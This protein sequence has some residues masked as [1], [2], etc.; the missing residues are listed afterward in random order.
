[1]KIL[2]VSG[3][4]PPDI[5]GP[6]NF[7]PKLA[8]YL[9]ASG[10]TPTVVTL[11]SQNT[12]EF[13]DGYKVIRIK[14]N[15]P[16]IIRIPLVF[17]VL[18]FEALKSDRLFSN[19]LYLE[20]ACCL[21]LTKKSGTAKIVGDQLW[22]KDFNNN[23]TQLNAMQFSL[24]R[25]YGFKTFIMRKL[26]NWSFNRFQRIVTPSELLVEL[27][28]IWKLSAEVSFI[29]NGVEL[30]ILNFTEKKYDLITV[31]RLIGLKR[32]DKLIEITSKLDLSLAI[33]GTGPAE[34]DLKILAKELNAKT[35]FFGY[36]NQ[37]QILPLLEQSRYFGLFSVHEGLSF[38]LLEA[39]AAGIP[40]IAS[41]VNGNEAV[42]SNHIDGYL[43]DV[44]DLQICSKQI[45]DILASEND[46][47][48]VSKNAIKKIREKYSL[49]LT[50]SKTTDAVLQS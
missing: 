48:L 21:L 7:I 27:S 41:R 44:D 49:E 37:N 43:V 9:L 4:Y 42:I 12:L 5:G 22:E 24:Q 2:L 36:S 35:T 14:R 8:E 47:A 6:A 50:L 11:G 29:P 39:M 46:Y 40:P 23:R 3:I 10:H 28:S 30:P 32:I 1:M 34:A 31:S 17:F 19:G 26:L 13:L 45:G 16:K 33:V 25:N 18:F 20:S 38:A 15:L